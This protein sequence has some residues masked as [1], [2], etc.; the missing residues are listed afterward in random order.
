MARPAP[1]AQRA[2]NIIDLLAAHGGEA[3]TLSEIVR[4]TGMSLGSAHA[5]LGTLEAGGYLSRHP[6][7]KA[8][9]LGPA[10]VAAG[11]VALDEQPGIRN[12]IDRAPELAERLGCEVVVTSAS[13]ET[14][15][16]LVRR[17]RRSPHGPDVRAGERIPL[18]P[19]LGVVFMAWSS[20]EEI[21]R[22]LARDP[23]T[24]E[25]A[26]RHRQ[27]ALAVARE[28]LYTVSAYSE[29]QHDFGALASEL[30][31]VPGQPELSANLQGL[32]EALAETPYAVSEVQPGQTYDVGTIAAPVFDVNGAVMAAITATGLEPGIPTDEVLQKAE[33]VRDTALLATRESGGRPPKRTS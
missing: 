10:L 32:L 30:A 28:R 31:S 2:L 9:S 6:I 7:N 24:D 11:F 13:S 16:V 14:I 29:A 22:W 21:D 8:Y 5:V 23:A 12:A 17:G 3:F 25:T 26:A 33:L 15:M 19:P 27:A 20:P 1:A 4:R 18:A